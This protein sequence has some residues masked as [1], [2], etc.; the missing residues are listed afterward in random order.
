MG[1]F[2]NP[3]D[4]LMKYML[5]QRPFYWLSNLI[6]DNNVQWEESALDLVTEN[7]SLHTICHKEEKIYTYHFQQS[8]GRDFDVLEI[9]WTET[10]NFAI[11]FYNNI[12]KYEN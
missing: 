11:I 6:K 2:R 12:I 9:M 3:L 1:G 7:F 8:K 10:K 4:N 5:N